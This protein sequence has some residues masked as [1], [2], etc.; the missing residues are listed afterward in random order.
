MS[1]VGTTDSGYK[2]REKRRRR[3][4]IAT[5]LETDHEKKIAIRAMAELRQSSLLIS[6]SATK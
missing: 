1:T 6:S 4:S 5:S 3:T 2:R